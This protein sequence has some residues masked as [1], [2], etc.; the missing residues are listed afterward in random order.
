[1][2]RH[3]LRCFTVSLLLIL[4]G[5]W[6]LPS[7]APRPLVVA[8][9]PDNPPY[10]YLD[11][12]GQPTGFVNDLIREV[13]ALEGLDIEIRSMPFPQAREAFE[14]GDVDIVSGM[15]FSAKRAEAMDF[16]TP[17]SVFSYVI[18]TRKGEDR[19]RSVQDCVG[20][21]VMV[22]GRSIMAEQLAALGIPYRETSSQKASLLELA[23]GKGDAAIV[24]KFMYL[25]F[26]KQQNFEN[27]Q[28]V[29]SE[30]FPT[31]RCFA[32]HKGERQL[33]AALNDGLFR[34][35]RNGT[36]DRIYQL[37]LGELEESEIPLA[38]KLRRGLWILGPGLLGLGLL[39]LLVWSFSLR[40]M[41]RQRTAELGQRNRELV[42]HNRE[43]ETL[44][45]MVA[46][47]NREMDLE[48][49]ME[50]LLT[51]SFSKFPKAE[52]GALLL[53]DDADGLFRIR[54]QM[55]TSLEGAEPLAITEKEALARYTEGAEQ[56]GEGIFRVIRFKKASR[57]PVALLAMS[58]VFDDQF[59]GFL[60]MQ[61]HADHG[62]FADLE[63]QKLSRLRGHAIA[64]LAK[65]RTLGR[66][67]TALEQLRERD[68]MKNQFMG[69]VA[70]DLRNPL[71]GIV[72]AAQLLEEEEDLKK[73]RH[74]AQKIHREGMEMAALIGR[75]LDIA[76]IE[77]GEMK[78]EP[79]T[80]DLLAL[81]RHVAG[82]YFPQAE[83][84][85]ITISFQ[86]PEVGAQV[87]ADP[88]FVKEV[89]DNLISN[90]VK[91]SRPQTL[92]RLRVEPGGGT[93]ITSVE[94]QGPGFTP[95]DKARL[96]GRFARLSAQPTGGE[97]STGLGLSIAKH[98]VEA[99]GGRIW[100]ESEAG[101]GAVFHV[102]LP[103]PLDPA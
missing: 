98:M 81:V 68:E 95:E 77:S 31:K 92:V 21:D 42:E 97:K 39:G 57:F 62:A 52:S 94:D 60:V 70:H 83:Q 87:F 89:L 102:G 76:R 79:E 51:V 73:V 96:F 28:A 22:L 48:S 75:F 58:L 15:V 4:G 100:L 67:V 88:K 3:F 2:A 46:V 27:L 45:Q 19:I 72:L 25:Y 84:K 66:L 7:Q 50:K 91:F 49:L 9:I 55:G 99:T 16:S 32:V 103:I 69:I 63:V 40:H 30:I 18:I 14:R 90:A 64:A 86:F 71:N 43:L 85:G 11:A 56:L 12:K 82:R 37:H 1:V 24:P 38:A 6:A 61:N 44:D 35:K 33:L 74:V 10:E 20:R 59:Q 80:C 34:L 23:A 47:I 53:K 101:H 5:G 54:F 36:L 41:V 29:P 8:S 26:T 93:I 65:V 78:A 13:A 17:H